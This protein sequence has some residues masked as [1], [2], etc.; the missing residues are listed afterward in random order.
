MKLKK[1]KR[2]I[3]SIVLTMA[4]VLTGTGI[5]T[6][7]DTVKVNASSEITSNESK[8][9]NLITDNSASQKE[10]KI[11][12]VVK[13]IKSKRTKNTNTYLLS[14]GTKKLEIFAEDIRYKENGKWKEYNAEIVEIN[15]DD[16]ALL[17]EM[18]VNGEAYIY[19]NT[20]GKYKHYFAE[21]INEE[22][23]VIMTDD[24]YEIKFAPLT[25]EQDTTKEIIS[26]TSD[27]EAEDMSQAE[28]SENV[29]IKQA[30]NSEEVLLVE[31][32]DKEKPL[33]LAYSNE[34]KSIEYEYISLN[35]GV[36]ESIILNKKPESN[37]FEFK[38]DLEGLEAQV[39]KETNRIDLIDK[40][41]EKLKANIE[42]PNIIDK[43]G[44][45]DYEH[46]HY[47]LKTNEEGCYI[48]SVIVDKE[49]IN[50]VE[51][52]ITIDPTYTW[53]N[54]AM[55]EYGATMSVGGAAS[56][57]LNKASNIT[58]M[59][60][61]SNKGRLYIKFDGLNEQLRG[62]Y[63][64]Y[65][66]FAAH[67]V[68]TAMPI[69]VGAYRVLGDWD[70]NTLTWNTQ[71]EI[72]DVYYDEESSFTSDGVN[73]YTLTQWA[74]EIA[75][76]EIEDDYGIALSCIGSELEGKYVNM[77]P[78]F[79]TGKLATFYVHYMDAEEVD[80]EYD[81]SFQVE[82]NITEENKVD[83]SWNK[84]SDDVNE[85]NIF[86]R[87]SNKFELIGRTTEL[88]YTISESYLGACTDIRVMAI[89]NSTM[90][91]VQNQA[92]HLENQVL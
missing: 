32:I 26:A 6:L 22:N 46:V 50:N 67:T 49:Y 16:K 34:S 87:N 58:L 84:F 78:L 38:L 36:K 20:Q 77:Y 5:S 90:M 71:P 27:V 29:E 57:V 19:T 79:T 74:K 62:K 13:E 83:L 10:V 2:R 25:E 12:K 15:E 43:S 68:N 41:T 8:T 65:S 48:L 80:C 56:S 3:L 18:D 54:D 91:I 30:E 28:M 64:Y 73:T 85:Y 47:E 14:D 53:I 66:Y 76:G 55:I 7:A 63:V 17:E 39:N 88:K 44:I 11:P 86:I 4:I 40:N 60:S 52:P 37:V 33:E 24:K 35:N 31:E 45:A 69:Y 81:G 51:Y 89:E 82:S 1:I 92:M 59:N 61:S 42:T 75:L 9:E 72:S 23:P 70:E 21:T